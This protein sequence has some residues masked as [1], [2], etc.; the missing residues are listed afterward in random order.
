MTTILGTILKE[1]GLTQ[2]FFADEIGVDPAQLNRFIKGTAIPRVDL[3]CKM[4]GL[5][6]LTVEELFP[7]HK[8]THKS[9]VITVRD[10]Q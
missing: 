1:K 5:L 8:F 4:A 7:E 6:R 9:R 10:D 3:A 2:R